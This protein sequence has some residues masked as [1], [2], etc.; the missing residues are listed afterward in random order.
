METILDEDFINF[1]S[2]SQLCTSIPLISGSDE[3]ISILDDEI[4]QREQIIQGQIIK[5]LY[6]CIDLDL[7]NFKII[8]WLKSFLVVCCCR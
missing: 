3:E 8:L 4:N 7:K 2:V 5:G 6:A 1:E